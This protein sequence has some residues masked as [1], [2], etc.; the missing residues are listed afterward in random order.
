[1]THYTAS[2]TGQIREQHSALAA[3]KEDLAR[4][5]RPVRFGVA[6][7]GDKRV[8]VGSTRQNRDEGA[9]ERLNVKVSAA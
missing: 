2:K 9:S 4:Q 3:V 5:L 7:V 8:V 1:M 6:V